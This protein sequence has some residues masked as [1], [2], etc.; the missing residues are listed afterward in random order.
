MLANEV[1]VAPQDFTLS[2]AWLDL[3]CCC[4]S[5][6]HWR[7]GEFT[8]WSLYRVCSQTD[9][10]FCKDLTCCVPPS[11]KQAIL[12]QKHYTSTNIK[13]YFYSTRPNKKLRNESKRKAKTKG[14]QM[15]EESVSAQQSTQIWTLSDTISLGGSGRAACCIVWVPNTPQVCVCMWVCMC[16]CVCVRLKQVCVGL[17]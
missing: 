3:C 5:Q 7:V 15:N 9:K 17:T 12:Y 8:Y 4:Q 2:K 11:A 14:G 16:V 13:P 6:W 10:L 1:L